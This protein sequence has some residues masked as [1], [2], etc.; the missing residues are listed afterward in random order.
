VTQQ[1]S[2]PLNHSPET[3]KLQASSQN[4]HLLTRE[5]EISNNGMGKQ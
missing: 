3:Q 2:L 4:K 5:F 1:S